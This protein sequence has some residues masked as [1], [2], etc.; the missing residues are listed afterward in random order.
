[1]LRLLV[2]C[3]HVVAGGAEPGADLRSGDV[4]VEQEAQRPP[5]QATMNG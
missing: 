3:A 5:R 1:M 4:V 2:E